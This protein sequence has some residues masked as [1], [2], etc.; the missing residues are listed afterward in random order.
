M[1]TDP[2]SWRPLGLGHRD[3]ARA[4][5]MALLAGVL[6]F[7]SGCAPPAP[8]APAPES[9]T[10]Q[11]VEAYFEICAER[12]D[13]AAF[14]DFFAED[15]VVEDIVNGDLV[16][17]QEAIGQFFNWSNPHVE[18]LESRALVVRSLVVEGNEAVAHGYFTR[19]RYDGRELGP[20][21]FVIWLVLDPEGRI[22]RRTDF[23]HYPQELLD[24]TMPSSNDRV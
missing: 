16:E 19:F 22:L 14:L 24:P 5:G 21:R 6:T 18:R 11:R 10:R 17:G 1:R 3:G 7:A 12:K 4:R 15:A 9:G 20:W 23:I 13:S 2:R 8:L